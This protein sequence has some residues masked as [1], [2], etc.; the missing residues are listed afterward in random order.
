M[1]LGPTHRAAGQHFQLPGVWAVAG[2]LPCSPGLFGTCSPLLRGSLVVTPAGC[3]LGKQWRKGPSQCLQA[4]RDT[5]FTTGLL[6]H[7][8]IRFHWNLVVMLLEKSW[9]TDHP[10]WPVRK[11]SWICFACHISNRKLLLAP[12]ESSW[13]SVLGVCLGVLAPGQRLFF[14]CSKKQLLKSL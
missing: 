3:S 9:E 1:R 13:M 14:F 7:H 10:C 6:N 12:T 4:V 8:P 2:Q 11:S 5:W